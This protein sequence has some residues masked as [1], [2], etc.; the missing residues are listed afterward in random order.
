[1]LTTMQLHTVASGLLLQ[2][3]GLYSLEEDEGKQNAFCD[4]FPPSLVFLSF[5]F[6]PSSS[7]ED[8]ISRWLSVAVNSSQFSPSCSVWGQI[9]LFPVSQLTCKGQFL[10]VR[11]NLLS[12]L[13]FCALVVPLLQNGSSVIVF[14]FMGVDLK[15]VQAWMRKDSW[16]SHLSLC[17]F[18][19]Q[20]L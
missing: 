13:Y 4:Y 15:L 16:F 8:I 5:S 10:C 17:S 19:N 6:F 3:Q 12:F 7:L 18:R 14:L 2:P 11:E 20:K 9:H 1:M